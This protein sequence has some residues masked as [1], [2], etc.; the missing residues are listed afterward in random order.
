MNA[1]ERKVLEI[2]LI[3]RESG[4]RGAKPTDGIRRRRK[5]VILEKGQEFFVFDLF[6]VNINCGACI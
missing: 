1:S 4:Q 6:Y 2:T 3:R 5:M